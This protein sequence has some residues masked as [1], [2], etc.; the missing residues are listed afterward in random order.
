[1]QM[2]MFSIPS[3]ADPY[4]TDFSRLNR[5][6]RALAAE[7]KLHASRWLCIDG[8]DNDPH[9]CVFTVRMTDSIHSLRFQCLQ[10]TLKLSRRKVNLKAN[11]LIR[12]E[13]MTNIFSLMPSPTFYNSVSKC[14][15]EDVKYTLIHHS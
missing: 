12:S 13:K 8:A 4:V 7:M 2:I 1:M 6:D 10:S 5:N 14:K 15:N 3:Q 11:C 9:K